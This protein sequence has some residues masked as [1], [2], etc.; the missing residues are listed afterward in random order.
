MKATID[1]VV[2]RGPNPFK[3]DVDEAWLLIRVVTGSK[4][5][6][7]GNTPVAIFNLDSEAALF[8]DFLRDGGTV[9][10]SNS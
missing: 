9:R 8:N 2:E 6:I 4:G 1:Y 3:K 5:Q 10:P 7:L